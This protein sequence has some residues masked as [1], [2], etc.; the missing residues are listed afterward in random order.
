MS[1]WQTA[2][3][4]W[5]LFLGLM[6]VTLGHGLMGSLAG[7]R[8]T[9]EGHA[10]DVSGLVLSGFFL[11]IVL[12]ALLAPRL[13]ERVGHVRV[14]G[15][16]AAIAAVAALAHAVWVEPWFWFALRALSGFATTSLYIVV[17]SWVNARAQNAYRGRLLSIY[18]LVWLVSMS[19]GQLL[20]G[21]ADPGGMLLFMLCSGL[22]ALAVVPLALATSAAP[23]YSSPRRV[24]LA[25][26]WRVTPL[27]TLAAA[28]IGMI[29]GT[30]VGMAS[31]YAKSIGLSNDR[32]AALTAAI[33]VGGIFLQM[34]I[35]RLSDR[36]DRRL[37][38]AG[39]AFAAALLATAALLLS[40]GAYWPLV[41]LIGLFGGL[42]LPL[43]SLCL[44]ITNDRLSQQEMVGASATIYLLVGLGAAAGP[45]VAG[46]LMQVAGPDGF[47][48]YLA[49]LLA[50]LGLL[51]LYRRAVGGAVPETAIAQPTAPVMPPP[52]PLVE[53]SPAEGDQR[54]SSTV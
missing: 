20:L 10:T 11:G 7:V 34:P 50:L 44:A 14:F 35:G 54:G 24:S 41:V 1:V 5:A 32:V 28:M 19:T 39:V 3:S 15:A 30:L 52:E 51:A 22:Y 2:W 25:R 37:V 53:A 26:L 4:C 40:E 46:V 17:E 47:L 43:Y 49:V 48:L 8:L 29:H 23:D 45:P 42:C 6:L 33:Y 18:M 31:V 38:L 27:G 16:M 9:L 12:A 36:L 13:I 21:L